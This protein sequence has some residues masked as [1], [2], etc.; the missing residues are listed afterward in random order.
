MEVP[1]PARQAA[2]DE[3]LRQGW[4]ANLSWSHEVDSTNNVARR[5]LIERQHRLPAL[6]VADQQTAGRGRRDH[7]WWSPGGC[8]ML[9]VALGEQ[10]LPDDSNCW[11]QLALVCGVALSETVSEFVGEG[12]AQL[13]WPNDIYV[14]DRKVGG[15]LIESVSEASSASKPNWLIGIGL[16]VAVD[17]SGAPQQLI[18]RAT[19]LS[20]QV[21]RPLTTEVVLVESMRRLG[22]WLEAWQACDSS[23]REAWSNGCLLSGKVVRVR[24]G[25]DEEI[26]GRC[27]GVDATGRLILRDEGGVKLLSSGEVVG[28][29]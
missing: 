17:W 29:Y 19:C 2:I 25:A 18:G 27:E 3:I 15:I 4:I 8:L 20:T 1:P 12:Q 22:R 28:W 6:F 23:W 9:T 26:S 16:N 21:G 24:L 7:Q 13:K 11:S 14:A 10:A 5:A